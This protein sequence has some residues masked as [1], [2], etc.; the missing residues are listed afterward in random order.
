MKSVSKVILAGL[1]TAAVCAGVY[2]ADV[3]KLA[4]GHFFIL[5]P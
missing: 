3:A 5:F 1:G 2:Y 4:E